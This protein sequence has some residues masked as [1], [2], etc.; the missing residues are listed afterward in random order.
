MLIAELNEYELGFL[1]PV[2]LVKS[3]STRRLADCEG[4]GTSGLA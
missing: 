1:L 3:K 2:P 4:Q